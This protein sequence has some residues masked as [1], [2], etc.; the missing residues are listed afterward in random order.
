MVEVCLAVLRQDAARVVRGVAGAAPAGVRNPGAGAGLSWGIRLFL[1]GA[2][3]P[4]GGEAGMEHPA[5]LHNLIIQKRAISPVVWRPDGGLRIDLCAGSGIIQ[6][7]CLQLPRP[8]GSGLQ[9]Q[10]C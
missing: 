3:S 4:A 9:T 7:V 5:P 1:P 10:S 6:G 2:A 8:G